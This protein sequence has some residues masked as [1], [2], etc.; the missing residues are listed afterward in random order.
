MVCDDDKQA[1]E[2]AREI[3]DDLTIEIWSADR[4]VARLTSKS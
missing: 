4:L 1:I 3:L 2:K